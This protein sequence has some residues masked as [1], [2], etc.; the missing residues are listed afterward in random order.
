MSVLE[1]PHS[2]R[3]YKV[4][5]P[6]LVLVIA[7]I[8]GLTAYAYGQG[9]TQHKICQA[10]VFFGQQTQHGI[11]TNRKLIK[12]DQQLGTKSALADAEIRRQSLAQAY[13]FLERIDRVQC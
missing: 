2:P 1:Q 8:V 12:H 3:Y 4:V 11:D 6:T 10:F 5:I 13:A 9:Q 7:A